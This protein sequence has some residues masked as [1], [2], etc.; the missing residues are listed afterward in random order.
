MTLHDRNQRF[1]ASDNYA[2]I[3]PVVLDA[4]A[5]ANGG[6]VRSYG[7]DPYTKTFQERIEQMFGPQARVY[8]TLTGTGS[9]VVALQALAGRHE[10]VV[11]ARSAHIHVDEGGAP[12]R[13]G[14]KLLTVPTVDGKLTVEGVQTEAWGWGD[15][16]RGQP[17]VLSITQSS[18]LGT[19]YTPEEIVA[20]STFA[21]GH[22]MRVHLDGARLANAA[23]HLGTSVRSFTTDA[24]ID[25]VS[26]GAT[27]N[28]AMGAE[29]VVVLNPSAAQYLPYLRKG[30]AQ[31][32]SK[33]RFVS[34]QFLALLDDDL[35]LSLASNA[36]SM[37]RRLAD[38]V[39]GQHG[40]RLAHQ[41]QANAVFAHVDPLLAPELADELGFYVWDG[42]SGLV[43]WMTSWDS[44][45]ES[46]DAFTA[47]L[48]DRLSR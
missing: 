40:I 14:L 9:N 30:S 19:V 26:F 16:H 44:T 17:G 7:D 36:N 6:H 18:E 22:G 20:L 31:L 15:Q 4:I 8:P 42:P 1:F 5:G 11:C 48:L 29:A 10:S 24:G 35:W 25:V 46:V 32:A 43:R 38:S 27:K 21:H 47:T 3:H 41:V 37:A 13:L 33:M 34:A 2:G 45:E 23:A 12:E 28:G 39:D